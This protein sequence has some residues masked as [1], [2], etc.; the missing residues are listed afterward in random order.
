MSKVSQRDFRFDFFRGVALLGIALN[1]T[2]PNSHTIQEYGHYQ[3]ARVFAFN[4]A[5]VFVFVSGWVCGVVYGTMLERNGFLQTQ[6]KALGR[7]G[8][9]AVANGVAAALCL[10]LALGFAALGVTA[11]VHRV[12][13]D[14]TWQAFLGTALFFDPIPFF[15]ILSIYVV[16]LLALPSFLWLLQK[17]G[18]W[19]LLVLALPYI[20]LNLL[21][22]RGQLGEPGAFFSHP[23]AWQMLFFGAAYLG[24]LQRQGR[25]PSLQPA[26]YIPAALLLLWA[27]NY[28]SSVGSIVHH[29]THKSTAGPLR[30]LQLLAVS[31]VI[32]QFMPR[33]GMWATRG[34]S[35]LI[36]RSGQN[37]LFVFCVSLVTCYGI[38]LIASLPQVNRVAYLVLLTLELAIVLA[39]GS[40]TEIKQWWM[41]RNRPGNE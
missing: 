20:W 8:T 12:V 3:F 32:S 15:N 11:D 18:A 30:I 33:S 26:V 38:S 36:V 28:L 35:G 17:M 27:T 39:S 34:W 9:L 13:H 23:G 21:A 2:V 24:R 1:H 19:V 7:C 6:K 31:Y 29:F 40:V 41:A 14:S 5:D 22:D 37:S 25:L 4:F 16:F 10:A